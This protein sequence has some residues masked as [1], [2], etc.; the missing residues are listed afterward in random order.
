[1]LSEN[2]PELLRQTLADGF[3][4]E[5]R[6]T[7]SSMSPLVRSGDLITLSPPSRC[8]I[9]RGAV[10]AYLRAGRS[11]VVHRVVAITGE[12]LLTR[13]DA[14]RRPDEPVAAAR[15]LG[16]LAR[17]R[18]R[19]R[20]LRLGLGPERVLIAWLS[21]RGWLAGLLSPW[22]RLARRAR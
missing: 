9:R 5:L 11:L 4:A 18:R 21:R 12:E 2:L 15:V 8:P 14:M 1:M 22:R 13:G 7:G 17:H 16:V 3:D 6:V 10:V 19:G 20:R